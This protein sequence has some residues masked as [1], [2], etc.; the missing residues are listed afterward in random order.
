MSIS[1][2]E[3][4]GEETANALFQ[5]AGEE[6][7]EA[8]AETL[9]C[10]GPWG[11][12]ALEGTFIV[13]EKEKQLL[14][15][16]KQ[17]NAGALAADGNRMSANA[18]VLLVLYPEL[19]QVQAQSVNGE[20]F[21]IRVTRETVIRLLSGGKT[22]SDYGTSPE[23]LAELLVLLDRIVERDGFLV[24]VSPDGAVPYPASGGFVAQYGMSLPLGAETA[25]LEAVTYCEGQETEQQVVWRG[26]PLEL[27]SDGFWLREY[28]QRSSDG[29]GPV[30][31]T[32]LPWTD[33]A[34]GA[35]EPL[36]SWTIELPSGF[37][38]D[39]RDQR[40][41][42]NAAE[43]TANTSAVLFAAAFSDT[44]DAASTQEM[45][46]PAAEELQNPAVLEQT[47]EVWDAVIL[48]QLRLGS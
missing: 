21:C 34:D 31:F 7:P 43:L 24:G 35:E 41:V 32:L 22:L 48:V 44:E 17:S 47:L 6:S 23:A 38:Y 11:D 8:L 4:T 16:F 40:G 2:E 30:E 9:V 46:L 27:P 29:W 13:S 37:H 12:A 10:S 36:A 14:L 28:P 26:S 15:E 39:S 5:L 45:Q 18:T 3:T 1:G 33:E 25:A 19:T 20:S 42:K